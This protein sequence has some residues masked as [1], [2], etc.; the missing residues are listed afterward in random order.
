MA[1]FPKTKHRPWI[2]KK[3][4]SYGLKPK[5]RST[6]DMVKFYHSK[7]WKSL[8][9]YYFSMNPLCE[10]CER[11]GYIIEGREVDHIQPMRL[12]GSALSINNL[13]TLCKSCH[14]RKS[15]RES[16]IR[17]TSQQINLQ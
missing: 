15:G 16:R 8:R 6:D 14:A 10:E 17:T 7:R 4:R 3:D 13:Q 12:G 1:S 11:S 5:S 9:N 2:P